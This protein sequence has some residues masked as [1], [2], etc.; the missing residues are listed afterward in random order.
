LLRWSTPVPLIAQYRTGAF[1]HCDFS[2]L[3]H[4]C[5]QRSFT[6]TI[7]TWRLAGEPGDNDVREFLH[8]SARPL[9]FE[10]TAIRGERN[11]LP[12]GA[13]HGL[14]FPTDPVDVLHATSLI[15]AFNLAYLTGLEMCG[16]DCFGSTRGEQLRLEDAQSVS[17][18]LRYCTL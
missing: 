3:P 11:N 1:E 17:R 5:E 16:I 6:R 8:R 2:Y 15:E 9:A 10:A 12:P 18:S 14:T 13:T 7:I 4:Y